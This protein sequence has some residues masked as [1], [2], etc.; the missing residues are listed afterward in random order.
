MALNNASNVAGSDV[1]GRIFLE[2]EITYLFYIP[3]IILPFC[4][5]DK[6]MFHD[7]P[8]LCIF[9]EGGNKKEFP[10][11]KKIKEKRKRGQT[12]R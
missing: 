12:Y 7:C 8:S 5:S 9:A 2:N 11:V 4:L 6:G 10:V 1:M 3:E